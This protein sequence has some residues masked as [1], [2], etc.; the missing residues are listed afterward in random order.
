M[1]M[2]VTEK[3]RLLGGA[4]TVD[5]GD[6]P[7]GDSHESL[8]LTAKWDPTSLFYTALFVWRHVQTKFNSPDLSLLQIGLGVLKQAE[9]S[10]LTFWKKE[11]I[12]VYPLVGCLLIQ[13]P[14]RSW[15]L[16]SRRRT[17]IWRGPDPQIPKAL[18]F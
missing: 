6:V 12:P 13:L 11:H 1:V 2:T 15:T 16:L 18:A 8:G 5:K 4:A 10:T 7:T 17:L 14:R 3:R 9:L